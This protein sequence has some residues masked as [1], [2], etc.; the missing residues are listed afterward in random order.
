MSIGKT[1][2]LFR[3][4]YCTKEREKKY[5][6]RTYG[7][8]YLHSTCVLFCM[9][10]EPTNNNIRIWISVENCP[11]Q[12]TCIIYLVSCF[13]SHKFMVWEQI[14]VYVFLRNEFF[15]SSSSFIF[16]VQLFI[17]IIYRCETISENGIRFEFIFLFI[18]FQ[19]LSLE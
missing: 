1:V 18:R 14:F 16:T 6:Q 17:I 2:S 4:Y 13:I 9:Q 11:A 7:G 15:S 12:E 8:I 19:F 5:K 3:D 10:S